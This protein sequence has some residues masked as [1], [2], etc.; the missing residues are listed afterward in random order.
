M[1]SVDAAIVQAKARLQLLQEQHAAAVATCAQLQTRMDAIAE[2]QMLIQQASAYLQNAAKSRIVEIVQTALDTVFPDEYTF[3]LEFEEKRGKTEAL[4]ALEKC[5]ERISPLDASG[6]GVADIVAFGLRIALWSISRVRN[7]IVLDEPFKFLSASLRPRGAEILRM[8]SD[9]MH[10]QFIIVTHD[11]DIAT[12]A[13][14]TFSVIQQGGISKV[15][16]V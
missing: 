2:V 12:I 1:K 11:A 8:L 4:L 3:V 5:G 16:E 13:D 15:E 14:R 10:L 6:G 9:K 7:L